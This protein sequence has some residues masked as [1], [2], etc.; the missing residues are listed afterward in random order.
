[1]A[2]NRAIMPEDLRKHLDKKIMHEQNNRPL[3]GFEGY[4]PLEMHTILH[5]TFEKNSPISFQKP[6]ANLFCFIHNG[7]L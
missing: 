7:G 1:M 2:F 4:S 5:L 6:G 3:Q